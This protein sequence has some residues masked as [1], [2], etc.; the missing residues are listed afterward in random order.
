MASSPR[1]D[2][3]GA[4]VV[5]DTY[6]RR[7]ATRGDAHAARVRVAAG[8]GV[9][10]RRAAVGRSRGWRG[11]REVLRLDLRPLDRHGTTARSRPCHPA[12]L[13][14]VR[15]AGK[16]RLVAAVFADRPAGGVP[17]SLAS[18]GPGS[19][20]S[21]ARAARGRHGYGP[22][23]GGRGHSRLETGLTPEI[24]RTFAPAALRMTNG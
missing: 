13:A 19:G 2:R 16:W 4:C 15:L 12:R 24:S 6:R 14:V 5:R 11:R 7:R 8:R 23:R 1:R 17:G 21:A 10:R 20:R 3:G 22:V 9:V 18:A